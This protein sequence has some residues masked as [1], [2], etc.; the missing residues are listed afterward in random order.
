MN[1]EENAAV[2]EHNEKR[3]IST[4]YFLQMIKSCWHKT[5]KLQIICADN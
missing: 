4:I 2:W 3:H 5:E 1:G